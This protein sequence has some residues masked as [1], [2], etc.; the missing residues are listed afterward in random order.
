MME[1]L[2]SAPHFVFSIVVAAIVFGSGAL[3]ILGLA[4]MWTWRKH[5][6]AKMESD[7]KLEMLSAG[8]SAEE[9][10]RVLAAKLSTK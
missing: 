2:S 4:G 9:I 3:T 7:L 5:R 8:M 6:T 1:S 10:E